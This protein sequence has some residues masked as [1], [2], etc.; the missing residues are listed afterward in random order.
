MNSSWKKNIHTP[1]I[2]KVPVNFKIKI[3]R[4]LKMCNDLFYYDN[5]QGLN[6]DVQ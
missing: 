2:G 1:V 6:M 4:C 3:P 5:F